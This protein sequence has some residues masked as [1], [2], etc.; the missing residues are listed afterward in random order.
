MLTLGNRI[1]VDTLHL[2]CIKQVVDGKL[3]NNYQK[4]DVRKETSL[5]MLCIF[6][7]TSV[8]LRLYRISLEKS[9]DS[10]KFSNYFSNFYIHL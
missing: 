8:K 7:L 2:K 1:L 6:F 5:K 9:K 3:L 4:R 10:G